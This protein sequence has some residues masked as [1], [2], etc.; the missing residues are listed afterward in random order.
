MTHRIY[1]P[2]KKRLV[3]IWTYTELTWDGEQADRYVSGLIAAL[4]HIAESPHR[5]RSISEDG[6]E[7]VYYARYRH[8]FIFFRKLSSGELGV[9]SILHE[10]MDIP[11]QLAEDVPSEQA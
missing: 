5:W 3:D 11:D 10:N 6:F 9:V 2:A 8:H 1:P 4:D 7:G